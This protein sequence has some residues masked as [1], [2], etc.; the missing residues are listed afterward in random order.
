MT[1]TTQ[2]IWKD[3]S[4]KYS[5]TKWYSEEEWNAREQKVKEAII[6]VGC[7]DCGLLE[8]LGIE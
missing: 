3:R 6:K 8:E 5:N 2:E 1:T 7:P 4:N